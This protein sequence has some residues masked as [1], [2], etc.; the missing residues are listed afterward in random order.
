MHRSWRLLSLAFIALISVSSV[1][2]FPVKTIPQLH[3]R[4]NHMSTSSLV[5]STSSPVSSNTITIQWA[6][7]EYP[8]TVKETPKGLQVRLYLA[9]ERIRSLMAEA[10]VLNA[11]G[12]DITSSNPLEIVYGS[13]GS[14]FE[15]AY[16]NG[17]VKFQIIG[18]RKTEGKEVRGMFYIGSGEKFGN[19]GYATISCGDEKVFSQ[20]SFNHPG[21]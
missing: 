21:V 2:T 11:L 3:S 19:P 17:Y 14:S 10:K 6:K 5:S 12:L 13:G 4:G 1:C 16:R 20:D 18:G 7:Q 9:K 8:S 15:K